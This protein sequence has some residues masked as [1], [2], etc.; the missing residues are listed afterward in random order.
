MC[1]EKDVKQTRARKEGEEE[2]DEEFS[3]AVNK[4]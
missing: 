4:G 1:K 3:L 2:E